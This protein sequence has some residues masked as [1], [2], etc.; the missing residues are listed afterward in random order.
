M[1]A[2]PRMLVIATLLVCAVGSARTQGEE[3]WVKY[4][5]KEYG[6]SLLVPTGTKFAEKEFGDG[7]GQLWAQ[8]EGVTLYGLAKLGERATPAEIERVGVKLT[9]IPSSAW[10]EIGK[11]ENK[12]G[13]LWY[14]TVEASDGDTLIIGDYGVGSRASYLLILVTTESDY[15]EYEADY[16]TWYQSIQLD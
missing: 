4:Q 7:W 15:R 5:A 9:G 8:H 14:R 6:F 12:G 3:T 1:R 11:G 2:L 13:W 10:K 16:K